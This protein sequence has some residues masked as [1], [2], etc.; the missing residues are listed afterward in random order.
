[1][2]SAQVIIVQ[3]SGFSSTSIVPKLGKATAGVDS[4]PEA[5]LVPFF[6]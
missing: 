3:V 6:G 4:F 1:M 5:S 2:F